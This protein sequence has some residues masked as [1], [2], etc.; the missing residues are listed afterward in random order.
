MY[1]IDKGKNLHFEI[2]DT[3]V[4]IPK[5]D[6]KYLFQKFFRSGNVLRHETQGS[7][8]GLYIASSIV[9]RSGGEIWFDSKE[10]KGSRFWF[11]LPYAS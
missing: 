11:T 9:K 1:V 3:G 8:L 7:G 4:G 5:E 10:H 2:E 6:Q